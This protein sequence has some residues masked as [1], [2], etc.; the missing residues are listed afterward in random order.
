MC[1]HVGHHCDIQEA[2]LFQT[3]R[4]MLHAIECFAKSLKI[5]GN[6]TIR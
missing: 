5:I 6:S 4:A 1:K 3:G 2:Q